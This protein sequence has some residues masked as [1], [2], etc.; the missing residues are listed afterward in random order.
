MDAAGIGAARTF[1]LKIL[2]Q[3]FLVIALEYAG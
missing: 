1:A 3:Q 2:F